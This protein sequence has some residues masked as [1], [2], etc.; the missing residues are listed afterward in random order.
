MAKP[1]SMRLDEY[2]VANNKFNDAEE[3]LRAIIAGDIL[4]DEIVAS[5]AATMVNDRSIVRVKDHK[6]FVSRGGIKLQGAIDAFGLDVT[7]FHC[8]D[9]GAS[10][11]G[12]TDCLLQNGAEH[13]SCVDVNYAQLDW[14]IRSDPR[15][16]VHE[17]TN[18]KDAT[19]EDIGAPFDLIVIDVSFIGLAS[20]ATVIANLCSFGTRLLAL[21][22][23]QFE[24]KRGE[25]PKG[26]VNDE[27]IRLRTVDEVKEALE[28]VGFAIDGTVES[29]I[30]GPAGNV[31][32]LLLATFQHSRS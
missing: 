25:A 12:F 1:G 8:L 7:G 15:V 10:T 31:E 24:S 22:K 6:P 4:V 11:G 20:L 30:K 27:R 5:S 3:A 28:L 16:E 2:L 18:I 26:V 29:Q 9:I 23:P 32:Y 21:I 19:P 17:R 14:K 13:V